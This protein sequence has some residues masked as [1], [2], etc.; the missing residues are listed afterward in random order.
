[1]VRKQTIIIGKGTRKTRTF[2]TVTLP[3]GKTTVV[4]GGR[5]RATRVRE[6]LAAEASRVAEKQRVAEA[7][8][9]AQEATKQAEKQTRATATQQAFERRQQAV[10]RTRRQVSLQRAAKVKEV[11][12][13]PSVGKP[14]SR[15]KELRAF[16]GI[17]EPTSIEKI[18]QRAKEIVSKEIPLLVT[19]KK[20]VT[21]TRQLV[22]K[23]LEVRKR[24]GLGFTIGPIEKA[25]VFSFGV[26]EGVVPTTVGGV[27]ISA[28]SFATG[29]LAGVGLGV[30]KLG[31]VRAATKAPALVKFAPKAKLFAGKA[32]VGL[33]LFVGGSVGVQVAAAPEGQRAQVL[34]RTAREVG[35]FVGGAKLVGRTGLVKTAAAK[36]E[37]ELAIQ[38]LPLEKQKTVAELLGQ[39]KGIAK[40][41]G[42][43]EEPVLAAERLPKE[44]VS[45][46]RRFLQREKDVVLGGSAVFPKRVGIIPEDIDLFAK[47][48]TK[49]R[50]ILFKQLQKAGVQRLGKPPKGKAEITIGGVKAIE[51]S[52]ISKIEANIRQVTGLLKPVSASFV[53]TPSGIRQFGLRTQLQRKVVGGLVDPA[54][55]AR[56]KAA[57]DIFQF[58]Q[59]RRAVPPLPKPTKRISLL[60]QIKGTRGTLR[61]PTITLKPLQITTTVKKPVRVAKPRRQRPS[62]PSQPSRPSQRIRPLFIPTP[63]GFP[64]QAQ[65]RR[66]K[67]AG[68]GFPSQPTPPPTRQ[69]TLISPPS[70]PP[71]SPPSQPT[72]LSIPSQPPISPLSQ[73]LLVSPPS[74]PP[75]RPPRQPTLFPPTT[76]P[77]IVPRPS[78]KATP[79]QKGRGFIPLVREKGGKRFFAVTRKPLPFNKARNL[80][81]SIVDRSTAA[82][83]KLKQSKKGVKVRDDLRFNLK[84]KFRKPVPRSP[85][86]G[87]GVSIEKN[88]N[89]IDSPGERAGI[90]AKGLL[91]L[92]RKR[93]RQKLT[94]VKPKRKKR[95]R[96]RGLFGGLG[97]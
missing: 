42:A 55:I 30:G 49:A 28:A 73:R 9:A 64:S 92:Q 78:L 84:N 56:G 43:V 25:T 34:G 50:D 67:R 66:A 6:A 62:Q 10:S 89:R 60:P 95:T 22:E 13:M 12:V 46:L 51:I 82:S 45:V 3:S 5:G 86:A 83:F 47:A 4:R 65:P 68:I 53:T 32:K 16:L 36:A 40:G 1:M 61:G 81:A 69:P 87:K 70:Q 80:A 23:E 59:V 90:T 37:L 79:R 63:R 71:V 14:L 97:L 24:L 88:K 75:V 41:F 33:E 29:G 57:K 26:A 58:A 8:Q 48:P 27:A 93:Q 96:S 52:P 15:G 39:T 18:R 20:G 91:A 54:R 74:Q 19:T 94:G 17:E 2:E 11:P 85:L 77:P 31:V 7:Q 38:K 76:R 44:A 21:A 35:S 72:L